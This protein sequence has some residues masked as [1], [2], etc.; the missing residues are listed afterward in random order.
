MPG[1]Y[2]V[3]VTDLNG[4]YKDYSYTLTQPASLSINV[5][6]S[7]TPDGVYNISCY[8]GT[9]S[10]NISVSGGSTGNYI[11]SWTSQNGSG[12]NPS[13]K[14]QTNLTAGTYNLHLTDLNGCSLDMAI[15]LTQPQPLS[16]TLSGTNITCAAAGF[17]NGRVDL[18]ISGGGSPYTFSWSNGKTTEDVNNLT[19]GTYSVVVTDKYGC[20]TSGSIIILLPPPLT[21]D[22]TVSSYN[23]FGVSCYGMA[24]GSIS[25][26][27]TSGDAPFIYQWTGPDGFV[28]T[29]ASISGLKAGTYTI[30]VT[31][32]NL[33]NITEVI[34]ISQPAKL[35][36]NI[37]LSQSISGGFNLNCAGD[38]TATIDIE[39]LNSVGTGRYIWA[40]G[41]MGNLRYNLPAGN[42][43]VIL[44]DKNNCQTDTIIAIT[45]PDSLK[46]SLE[47][48]MPF[49]SDMPDGSI[50]VN[51]TGGVI[52]TDYYFRWNDNSTISSRADVT[53][54]I[55]WVSVKDNNNCEVIDTIAVDT[56]NETCLVIPNIFSPNGDFINDEWN[57][58]MIYLYPKM[59]VT[60]FNRWGETVWKSE[61]G[62]PLPWDGR[63]NGVALPVDSY[64]YIIDLHNGSQVILGNVTIVK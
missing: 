42:Y 36:M 61:S 34:V 12:L 28:S 58:D 3:R 45:E 11:Y 9:G 22:K 43:E 38:K 60:I 57:M 44:T 19:Q 25:V 10:I 24:D 16:L 48:E 6:K 52:T 4:C 8:G 7:L 47:V 30:H 54:G 40:D 27:P 55:Y 41:A 21:I 17:D 53:K 46:T 56:Q 39:A 32:K 49:C 1:N 59:E 23:G 14:D 50:K 5:I 37:T 51:A 13:A 18:S 20:T 26:T 63:S 33:C 31:D 64:H 35:G 62:Y 2:S 15:T 29:S